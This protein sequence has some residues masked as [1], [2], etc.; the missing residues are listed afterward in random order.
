MNSVRK[1]S[2]RICVGFD[3]VVLLRKWAFRRCTTAASLT[4]QCRQSAAKRPFSVL[5]ATSSF[6]P[7]TPRE[8]TSYLPRTFRWQLQYLIPEN[9]EG[10]V[11]TPIQSNC[12]PRLQ[13]PKYA[14]KILHLFRNHS[15]RVINVIRQWVSLTSSGWWLRKW[16]LNA[17]LEGIT[18]Q[19]F[20]HLIAL[21]FILYK[22]KIKKILS[23]SCRIYSSLTQFL[24]HGN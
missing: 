12:H 19:H 18:S 16:R 15:T 13:V 7:T 1:S 2:T 4:S 22:R 8:G 23:K 6:S 17:R 3:K 21:A 10:S 14:W 9:Y 5:L 24:R 11:T 20:W